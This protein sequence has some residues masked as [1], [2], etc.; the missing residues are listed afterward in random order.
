MQLKSYD[1]MTPD[2]KM[3]YDMG[4]LDGP[5]DEDVVWAARGRLRYQYP[6][7]LWDEVW[8]PMRTQALNEARASLE[9]VFQ[10]RKERR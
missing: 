2:Q 9:A 8:G 7:L 6:D 5:T 1:E 10:A 3:A 4:R